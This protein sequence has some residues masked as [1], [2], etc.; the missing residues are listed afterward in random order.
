MSIVL[1]IARTQLDVS[2]RYGNAVTMLA[3]FLNHQSD[4]KGEEMR[5]LYSGFLGGFPGIG[6]LIIRLAVGAAFIIHGWPKVHNPMG[7]MNSI[8]GSPVPSLLQALAALTEFGGGIALILGLLTPLVSLALVVQMVVALAMVH[9]P[10]GQHF[11]ATQAGEPS[12][13]IPVIYLAIALALIALGPGKLS[14]DWLLFGSP[15]SART[16][17]APV[18]GRRETSLSYR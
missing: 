18:S 6:L 3:K 11:I 10:A 7:W 1:I 5:R 16:Y 14:V 4:N 17:R 2:G 15:G 8:W 12:F 13:E 9:L